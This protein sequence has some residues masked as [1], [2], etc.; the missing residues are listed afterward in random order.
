MGLEKIFKKKRFAVVVWLFAG[1]YQKTT[2]EIIFADGEDSGGQRVGVAI[3]FLLLC[4]RWGQKEVGW[5]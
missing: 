5:V 3:D 1:I 2:L 4:L